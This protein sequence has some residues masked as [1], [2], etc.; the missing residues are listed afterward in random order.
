[1]A[2]TGRRALV[3]GAAGFIGGHLARRL[4]ELGAE[5]HAV[6][7]E[8]GRESGYPAHWHR[9]DLRD[10]QATARLFAEVSPHVVFHLASEVNGARDTGVVLPTLTGNLVTT[11]NVLTAVAGLECRVVLAGS[12]EEPRPGNGQAAAPSPYAM[13]KSAASGYAD[14]FHRLWDVPYTIVRPSMVYGPAQRDLTKLVPYVTM[15]LLRG[16]DPHLTSGAKVADWVYVDDVVSAFAAAALSERAVCQ[17]VDVGTGVATSVRELVEMLFD[18]VGST[19]KPGFGAVADR[20]LDITQ[21]ADPG[22]ALDLLGWRPEVVLSDGL[23]RTV[24]WYAQRAI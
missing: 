9:A 12:I 17:A 5:V 14:L 16:D 13:A 3:T 18:I 4:A 23:R 20:P 24:A 15:A 6:S 10:A 21:L 11:V 1:M 8:P 19:A 22:P 2:W 7:R